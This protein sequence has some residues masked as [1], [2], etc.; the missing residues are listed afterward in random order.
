[1]KDQVDGVRVMESISSLVSRL[2]LSLSL[3]VC[4]SVCVTV[5]GVSDVD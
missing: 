2:S 4:L 5:R 3:S 1:M